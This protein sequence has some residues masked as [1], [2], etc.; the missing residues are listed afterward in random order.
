MDARSGV[1]M[2]AALLSNIVDWGGSEVTTETRL[3]VRFAAYFAS[4]VVMEPIRSRGG[5]LGPTLRSRSRN[6]FS[7]PLAKLP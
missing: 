1:Y 5:K 3:L 4:W 7:T 2:F 6:F